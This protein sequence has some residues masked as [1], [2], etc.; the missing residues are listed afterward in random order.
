LT[1]TGK[2]LRRATLASLVAIPIAANSAV[3]L[4]D[5]DDRVPCDG[6]DQPCAPED[7]VRGDDSGWCS[8]CVAGAAAILGVDLTVE[9]EP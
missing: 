2:F 9:G 3:V 1:E 7:L 5:D 8:G 4:R 6:C